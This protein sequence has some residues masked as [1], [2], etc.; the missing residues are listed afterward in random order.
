MNIVVVDYAAS[1]GGA[2]TILKEFYEEAKKDKKNSY[3]FLLSNN[4]LKETSN[5]K[6]AIDKT[7]KIHKNRLLF[8]LFTGKKIIK[9]FK[10]D[11]VFSLEN[12]I[13]FGSKYKQIVYI[14]QSIPFQSEKKFSF[15]KKEERKYAKIQYLLGFL[16]K[17]SAQKADKIIVQTQWMKKSINKK[18][19]VPQNK[20]FVITPQ[21]SINIKQT[22]KIDNEV[23]FYPTS[24]YLYKNNKI[25][26]DTIEILK[27]DNYKDFQIRLTLSGENT[28]NIK[29]LGK[30]SQK[31]VYSEIS[32][33]ILVFPSYIESYGLPL[34]EAKNIGTII[35]AS[36]TSFSHEILDDYN[37]AYFFN[38]F[39][40]KELATLMEKCINEEIKLNKYTLP[41]ITK[42]GN[43]ISI[44]E[45]DAE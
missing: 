8:D 28:K 7:K 13:I 4:Y 31:S 16:I 11:L 45:G 33:S 25:L 27:K 19:H 1:E 3:V 26:I 17:K 23:F 22:R 10:P 44:L 18:A 9:Q 29:H 42:P 43:I 15:L 41:T 24:D 6:I 35:L 34:L 36:D 39:S 40:E 37:N 12:T 21:T 32:K 20:I 30:I 38:P 5:I 14:H 2:M